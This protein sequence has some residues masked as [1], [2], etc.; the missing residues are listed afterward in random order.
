[1]ANTSQAEL[2]KHVNAVANEFEESE[3]KADYVKAAKNFRMPYWDWARPDLG[4]FPT[5]ATA[6][7]R[8][9]VKRP[10]GKQQ[11]FL[12]DPNPLATYRFRE[13]K[14]D[15]NINR[16]TISFFRIGSPVCLTAMISF[17]QSEAPFDTP[18]RPP[19]TRS[20]SS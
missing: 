2:Y 20:F 12:L 8:V 15:R 5:Q 17:P 13:S 7:A 4:V 3:R 19:A 6:Q 16:V 14:G 10:H 9:H 18:A 11:D 1:M